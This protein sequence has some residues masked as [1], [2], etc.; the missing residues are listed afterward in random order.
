MKRV[1]IRYKLPI[2][3]I[4]ILAAIAGLYEYREF[5]RRLPD[6]HYLHAVFNVE[7]AELVRRFET[8]ESRANPLYADETISVQGIVG[9]AQRTDTSA[10][11]FLNDGSS[12]ASVMCEFGKR[13]I[14]EVKNIRRGDHVRIKGICS[15]FL[16][17]VILVRC[18]VER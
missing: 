9:A 13:N 5:N 16:M 12:M 18:V 7:A 4:T 2:L 10:T 14:G 6:T 8:D 11:I 3:S 15:G 17:D 1:W